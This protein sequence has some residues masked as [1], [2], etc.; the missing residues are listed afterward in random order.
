MNDNQINQNNINGI[1]NNINSQINNNLQIINNNQQAS[2]SAQ[3][4]N[5]SKPTS[6]N[7]QTEFGKT[8]EK[9]KSIKLIRYKYKVKDQTGQIIESYFDAENQMDVQS[10]LLN[11]GY[12]IISIT[13]DKLSTSLGLAALST[14]KKMT[15]KDLNFFLTQLSTYVKSGIPLVDSMEILSR[16]AKSKSIQML[17]R[18]IV[19]ELNK[20]TTFS[21]CLEKQGKIFPKMLINML[22]TSEMTGD[23]TGVL[24]DMAAYYKQQDSNRKQ[25][26]NA[27]TY[28][29]VLMIFAV[30]VLTFVITYVVPSFTSMYATAG[31]SLPEITQIIMSISD[32]VIK[33]WYYILLIIFV[34]VVILRLLYKSSKSAKYT[35][36]SFVMH[37]P[38][39]S[40]M[41]KY[42]QL[43][44]FTGTF[45]TLIKHDVFITDSMDILSRITE[46]EIYK[47]IIE[48]AISNLSKGNG[49][50]VAFKGHWAFPATAYEMLVT[51][52]KTGKLGEMMQH[53]TEYY[54]EEQTSL[55]ARLKSLIEPIMIVMLAILVGIILLAVVVPMFDI[56]S[57][58]I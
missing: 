12:E 44:T 9:G 33:N 41:I 36:Q 24:D 38:V 49:V 34:I 37:I 3:N 8:V 42:N 13:E 53:V 10:F 17:Y 47:K 11:K 39:V 16:Q 29:S 6:K 58:I 20:G 25:I 31:A 23:L 40:D 46:N 19:F 54:Q 43:V 55:I 22:K 5:D 15:S 18:K 7:I 50:S 45:S 30:A 57:T 14:S 48:D 4:N 56:Y 21:V 2:V 27:M 1:E 26:I 52:E 28:P 35:M 32:F 51:G